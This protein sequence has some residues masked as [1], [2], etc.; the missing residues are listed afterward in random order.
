MTSSFNPRVPR[1]TRR[2]RV[3]TVASITCFFPSLCSHVQTVDIHKEKVAR[4]EIGILTINK[5]TAR[6]HKIIAPANMERPVRYIRK[7]I[8]YNVLDDVGHGV[9]VIRRL[10]ILF[11]EA[12]I[13][14]HSQS[15]SLPP[16]LFFYIP[17]PLYLIPSLSRPLILA[18]GI[19]ISLLLSSFSH[20]DSFPRSHSISCAFTLIFREHPSWPYR[21]IF[22]RGLVGMNRRWKW[23]KK[24]AFRK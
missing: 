10:R 11:S 5:N 18:R 9:K 3:S 12:R 4:R 22:Q 19:L 20:F 21:N 6:T 16:L 14:P 15:I 17:V 8:D 1:R 23:T 2:H 24:S 13:S 7:P